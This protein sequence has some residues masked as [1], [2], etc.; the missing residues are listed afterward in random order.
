M[1][2]NITEEE[3]EA[4]IICSQC[5]RSVCLESKGPCPDKARIGEDL[6]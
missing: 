6:E 1:S 2:E 3:M 4:A 5:T